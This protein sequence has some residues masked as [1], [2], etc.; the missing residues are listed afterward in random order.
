MKKFIIALTVLAM[1]LSVCGC[2]GKDTVK[3]ETTDT[4]TETPAPVKEEN[5]IKKTYNYTNGTT[6]GWDTYEYDNEGRLTFTRSYD[7]DGKAEPYTEEVY[8]EDGTH[9]ET[10]HYLAT[11]AL[12]YRDVYEY[13]DG[14]ATKKKSV[15]NDG[16]SGGYSVFEYDGNGLL[17][18]DTWYNESGVSDYYYVFEYDTAGK[19]IMGTH[20]S[21]DGTLEYYYETVYGEHGRKVKDIWYNADGT[22]DSTWCGY[23]YS[24]K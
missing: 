9:T 1:C 11:G 7:A 8:A 10:I 24:D 21:A 22:L 12:W 3:A 4:V 5:P 23:E 6:W 13:T 20:Y 17:V 18:K 14:V 19:C 16:S 2:E 15:M